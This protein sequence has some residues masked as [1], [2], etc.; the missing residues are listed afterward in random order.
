MIWLAG[1]TVYLLAVF[2]RTS[3]GVAGLQAS[4]R[5]GV[6]AAALGTFTVLQVGVYA[7]MQIPTGVL[8][9]RYGPRRILTAALLF[10]GIGQ[11]LMATADSYPLGLLARGVLGFGDALTFVS[12]VRLIAAHF[13]GRQYPVVTSFTTAVGYIGNLAATVPLTLLLAG[14]GWTPTF[15]VA[16]VVTALFAAVVLAVVRDD[17]AGVRREPAGPVSPRALRAQVSGAWRVPGTRL[18]FWLHFSTMFAPNVLTLIWGVP[19]LVQGQGLPA[20]TASA[21]MTVF[22]FGSMVGGPVV[23]ALIGRSPSWRMPI[24]GGYLAG[25][26]VVWAL[27]LSWPGTVP[28]AVLVPCFA[29]L[30]IGGPA[31]M[32]GFALAR[33]YNPLHRVGTATGVVNVGGFVATTIG[34]LV[35]GLLLE[36]TGGEFRWALLGIVTVLVLGVF[37]MLVWW[38]RARAAL[39]DAEARGEQIPVRIVRH[40]WDTP[41]G[42]RSTTA[43]A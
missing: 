23:G 26:V 30:S 11:V 29:F 20:A 27:L 13:S 17:P 42:A 38:R 7:A 12:V 37:R 14:P 41:V 9:D 15:L 25:A 10:L 40:R 35:F 18:G 4:E 1:A 28:A 36:L 2:H 5:F 3:F 39:F 31:S 32:I 8:V 43:A 6:G 34:A 16:G 22:V 33:D 21:L 24:V 19:Y